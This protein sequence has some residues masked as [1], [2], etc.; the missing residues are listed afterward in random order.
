MRLFVVILERDTPFTRYPAKTLKYEAIRS[1]P[2]RDM[3]FTKSSAQSGAL[4]Q[5][6]GVPVE[7]MASLAA[8]KTNVLERACR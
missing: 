8:T 7:A 3:L 1:D 4:E 2:E 6:A 5:V